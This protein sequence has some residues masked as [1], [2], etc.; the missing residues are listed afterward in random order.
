MYI[1]SN[2]QFL[3]WKK[4]YRFLV[5]DKIKISIQFLS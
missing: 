2:D 4:F 5:I 1:F 3:K